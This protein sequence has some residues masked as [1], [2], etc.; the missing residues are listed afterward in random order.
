[1]AR[2]NNSNRSQT[3]KVTYAE[4]GVDIDA[5]AAFTQALQAKQNARRATQPNFAQQLLLKS[6]MNFAS[7][8]DVAFLKDYAHPLL[9]SAC[10]GVGTKLH[11]AQLFDYHKSVGIDLVAMCANDLLCSGARALQFLD[12]IA[13]GKLQP[14]RME[15]IID[16]IWEGCTLANCVLAGG[17]T[18]EHPHL[19]PAQQYDLAGF[20]IGVVEKAKLLDG[21][22]LEEGDVLLGLPS[23]G[24]HANGFSLLRSLYLPNTLEL[25]RN[26]KERDFLFEKLLQPATLIY[27]PIVRELL[28]SQSHCKALAHITGGGFYENIPRILP[29]HLTAQLQS[30]AWEAP[31]LF[32]DIAKRAE[33]NFHEMAAIFNMGIGMVVAVSA[34]EAQTAQRILQTALSQSYPHIQAP[35]ARIGQIIARPKANNAALYLV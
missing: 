28:K 3:S 15:V 14:K 27:E 12:Y 10:D 17:E 29:T 5:G 2:H 18:A 1:M 23:S 31:A 24:A 33:L 7:L 35:V 26:S 16:S 30:D 9:V 25:P 13:C 21:S 32:Q 34:T 20:A 6:R 11:L 4:A 19:M 8:T 22:K